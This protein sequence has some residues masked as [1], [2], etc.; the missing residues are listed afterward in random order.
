MCYRLAFFEHRIHGGL[1]GLHADHPVSILRK[2]WADRVVPVVTGNRKLED[3]MV[4]QLAI[5]H[6]RTDVTEAG[7][8]VPKEW[9]RTKA[10][11]QVET[12]V[13]RGPNALG[14]CGRP[15]VLDGARA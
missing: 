15:C 7:N 3:L 12:H 8:T 14:R 13:V 10:V 5:G 9:C 6:H 11:Q 1:F 2:D 4:T